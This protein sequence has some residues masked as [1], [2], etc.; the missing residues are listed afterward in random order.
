MLLQKIELH[1]KLLSLYNVPYFGPKTNYKVW[2]EPILSLVLDKFGGH[3]GS[4]QFI[5]ISSA[6]LPYMPVLS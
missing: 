6:I 4:W 1:S 5:I 2:L 3:P